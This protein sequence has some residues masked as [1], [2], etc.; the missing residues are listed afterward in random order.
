MKKIYLKTNLLLCVFGSFIFIASNSFA[1][2]PTNDA[3]I[4][5][6]SSS[7]STSSNATHNVTTSSITIAN[8]FGSLPLPMP[9][10]VVA[11]D[12]GTQTGRLYRDGVPTTCSSNSGF[13]DYNTS[14]SYP[15]ESYEFIAAEDG[16]MNIDVTEFSG[17]NNYVGVYDGTYDPSNVTLNCI[18]QQGLS[19]IVSF[20]CPVTKGNIYTLVIMEA[21]LGSGTGETYSIT[22]DNVLVG[23]LV[24]ISIWSIILFFFLI[25]TYTI[26]KYKRKRAQPIS[27]EK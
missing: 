13:S 11:T 14:Y 15:Y 22:I 21:N 9:E 6:K 5:V 18:G 10:G 3:G 23:P 17:Y 12:N 20:S 19:D 24:P 2:N 16:C 8:T 4:L 7:I 27:I 1:Q 26:Y 25:S